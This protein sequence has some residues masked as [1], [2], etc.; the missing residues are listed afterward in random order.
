MNHQCQPSIAALSGRAAIGAVPLALAIICGSAGAA[1]ATSWSPTDR[2]DGSTAVPRRAT[3][4]SRPVMPSPTTDNMVRIGDIHVPSPQWLPNANRIEL[5]NMAATARTGISGYCR[6]T[7]TPAARC[8]RVAAATVTGAFLGGAAASLPLAAP[9]AL[10]GGTVG[11]VLGGALATVAALPYLLLPPFSIA[12]AIAGG[13]AG[14]TIGGAALGGLVGVPLA[15]AG[16][17]V[18]G[19]VGALTGAAA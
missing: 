16:G 7:G 17:L 15:T 3:D 13:V 14:A 4:I 19:A 6:S 2:P 5:N 18:G 1:H 8:D 9:V 11:G 12:Q 10:L